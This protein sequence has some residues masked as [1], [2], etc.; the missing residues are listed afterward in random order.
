[1]YK[2]LAV[3]RSLYLLFLVVYL[4]FWALPFF[5]SVAT[6]FD[7][8]YARCSISLSRMVRVAWLGVAWIGFETAVGWILASRQPRS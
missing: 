5:A 4:L 1:M 8:Q 3:L 2:A 7:E 6:T